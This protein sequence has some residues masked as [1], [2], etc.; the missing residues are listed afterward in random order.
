MLPLAL[1][2][3]D[4]L[5]ATAAAAAAAAARLVLGECTWELKGE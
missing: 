1:A 3:R 2:R 5:P 4:W